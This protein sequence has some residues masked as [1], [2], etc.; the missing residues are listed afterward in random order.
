MSTEKVTDALTK[1]IGPLPGFVYVIIFVGGYI[2]Y[3]LYARG[4]AVTMPVNSG[5]GTN[6][7]A[8]DSAG[9]GGSYAPAPIIPQPGGIPSMKTNAQWARVA[10]QELINA[11]LNPLT[12]TSALSKYVSGK[13]LSVEEQAAITKALQLIGQPPEGVLPVNSVP[14]YADAPRWY[15]LQP[16]DTFESLATRFFGDA[17][18]ANTLAEA[19]A[20]TIGNWLPGQR[21]FIPSSV[22]PTY[23]V[24]QPGDTFESLALTH[25]GDASQSWKLAQANNNTI[26]RWTPGQRVII[27]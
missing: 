2:A 13:A 20:D 19:N 18:H 27:P 4:G 1:K 5:L 26:G 11:G 24:L 10:A 22:S 6:A 8:T 21:V 23:Y 17:S 9:V 7:V 14:G 16:G 12:V 25:Y 3:R 15:V